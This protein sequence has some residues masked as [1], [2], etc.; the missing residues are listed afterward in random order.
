MGIRSSSSGLRRESPGYGDIDLQRKCSDTLESFSPRTSGKRSRRKEILPEGGGFSMN[1]GPYC[2]FAQRD[3]VRAV[4]S[5]EI[6]KWPGVDMMQVSHDAF[7]RG[8][9]EDTVHDDATWLLDFYDTFKDFVGK[10][11]LDLALNSLA[12]VEGRFAWVIY[13]GDQKRVL[14]ARDSE[15]C[16]ALHWGTT[17]DGRFI[18][19]SDPIDLTECNPSASP[20]PAG[21]LYASEGDTRASYPGDMGWVMTGEAWPGTLTS[22]V[23][24]RP[25]N[26]WRDIKAIPRVTS[27]GCVCG[28]VYRVASE[29][30][31][32]PGALVGQGPMSII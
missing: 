15:G 22:F 23:R 10:D 20:F 31:F 17:D 18:F 9:D 30:S 8:D 3:G 13:D 27:Q 26:H 6:S 24:G 21:T 32:Q 28:A 5:G 19:G 4:F 16:A 29:R 12:N 2:H 7:M 14:A 1:I 25:D 11:V